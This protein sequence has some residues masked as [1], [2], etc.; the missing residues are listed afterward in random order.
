MSITS[1]RKQRSLA[2]EIVGEDL[3]AEHAPFSCDKDEFRE[4]PFVYRPNLIAVTANT[5][6]QHERCVMNQVFNQFKLNL[7]Q[8]W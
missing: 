7:P 4:V 3:K 5:V 2:K 8:V 6:D 1:E